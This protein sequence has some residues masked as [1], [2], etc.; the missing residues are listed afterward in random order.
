MLHFVALY[1]ITLLCSLPVWSQERINTDRPHN[2]EAPYVLP[3]GWIQ[4][5]NGALF[6]RQRDGNSGTTL[7][8]LLRVGTG[9]GWEFRVESDTFLIDNNRGGFNDLSVGFKRV[10]L[11]DDIEISLLGR[12]YIPIGSP[13]LTANGFE[14]DLKL[15]FSYEINDDLELEA[16]I[17]GGLPLD[18]AGQGRIFQHFLAVNLSQTIN[19]HL[20]IYAEVVNIG[21]DI[22]GQPATT[23]LDAGFMI[24][25]TG[26]LQLDL[27][28]YRGLSTSGIDWGLGMGLSTRW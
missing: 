13:H 3:E 8:S 27:E 9:D 17:G 12:L 2:A 19:D 18:K 25:A 15:A 26:D 5:E 23:H 21:S 20:G 22:S 14:P 10:L 7:P 11:E 4:T 16:N 1:L 28:Y 24:W 6:L